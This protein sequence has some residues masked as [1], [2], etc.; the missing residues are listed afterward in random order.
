MCFR[1]LVVSLSQAKLVNPS[2]FKTE[3]AREGT[4]AVAEA[5]PD[6]IRFCELIRAAV[7]WAHVTQT[8]IQIPYKTHA[9]TKTLILGCCAQCALPELRA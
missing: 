3:R 9:Q 2:L 4:A 8:T 6:D 1:A 5:D 7:V